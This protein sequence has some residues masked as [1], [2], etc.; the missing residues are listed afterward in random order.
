MV[1]AVG[2]NRS[3]KLKGFKIEQ[4]EA[5]DILCTGEGGSLKVAPAEIPRE[6]VTFKA[7]SEPV[8]GVAYGYFN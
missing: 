5:G 1:A 3:G 2:D 6:V 4:C 7:M 8:D